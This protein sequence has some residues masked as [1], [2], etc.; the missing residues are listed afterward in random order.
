MSPLQSIL[1]AYCTTSH[2]EREEG[3]YFEEL[4]RTFFRYESAAPLAPKTFHTNA[5]RL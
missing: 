4:I 3:S 1:A 5:H 2:S